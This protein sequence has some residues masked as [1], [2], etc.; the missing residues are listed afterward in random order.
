VNNADN[1]QSP[2]LA[3]AVVD[4]LTTL[5]SQ[6]R[7]GIQTETYKFIRWFGVYRRASELNPTNIASYSDQVTP[8][9]TK[10]IKSFLGHI[11]GRGFTKVNLAGHLRAKKPSSKTIS[12]RGSSQ[13][14]TILT[15][16]G[17][18]ELEA[19][20]AKLKNQR[21][22]VIEEI[23]KAAADKD[24]RE[25]APLDAAREHKAHLEGRIQKLE[26][27]LKSARVI[28]EKQSTAKIEIG[29]TVVL[30]DLSS[31]EELRYTLVNPWEASPTRGKISTASPIGKVL[32][33]KEKGQTIE[34]AAPAGILPYC[35]KDIQQGD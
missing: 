20:L 33:G 30:H 2:T 11:H 9:A 14:Q 31:G 3:E 15:A 24:F 13:A 7:E 22:N 17:F 23:H 5:E 19:E 26:S 1:N 21:S 8:S 34:V 25:N 4:F 12:H 10:Q 35:V 28:D 27:R 6:E 18:D 16:Q 32:L 29:D